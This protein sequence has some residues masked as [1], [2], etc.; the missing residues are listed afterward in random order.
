MKNSVKIL[1]LFLLVVVF[2]CGINTWIEYS[3]VVHDYRYIHNRDTE[4]ELVLAFATALRINHPAAYD[5]IDPSL[6]PRLDAWMN[7]HQSKKC[8][9]IPEVFTAAIA[10]KQ[11]TRTVLL[12]LGPNNEWIDFD[13]D[14]IVIKDMKVIDWGKVTEAV[15]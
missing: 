4:D 14:N 5:M 13:V 6:K 8:A 7:T 15:E 9:H 10:T 2:A 11:G 3:P 1:V 12:C